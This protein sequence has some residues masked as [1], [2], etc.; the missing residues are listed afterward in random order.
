M[1]AGKVDEAEEVLD[2]ILPSSDETAEVV[3][4]GKE[5][6]YFPAFSIPTQPAASGV[7]RLRR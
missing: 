6:L 2:E 7:L 5:P 3:H 1:E 4:P